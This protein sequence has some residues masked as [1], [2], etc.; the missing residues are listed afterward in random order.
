MSQSRRNIVVGLT[1]LGG[2]LALGWMMLRYGSA[3]VTIFRSTPQLQVHFIGDRADGLAEGS[4]VTY[5]GVAVGSILHLRRDANQRDVIIDAQV[6]ATPP[7]PGNVQGLVRTQSLISG[8]AALS[9][10][11]TGP[12]PDG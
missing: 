4:Q 8:Q 2:L 1:V 11:L 5:R 6:D 12:L 9:L 3:P 7:L 10:E